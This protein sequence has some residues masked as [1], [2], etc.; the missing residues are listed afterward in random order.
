MSPYLYKKCSMRGCSHMVPMGTPFCPPCQSIAHG[1]E[2]KR[3]GNSTDR[4]YG[5]PWPA[6]RASY[7]RRHPLCEDCLEEGKTVPVYEVHHKIAI[8]DGGTHAFKNLRSLC[9]FHHTQREAQTRVK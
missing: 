8:R 1:Q 7:V 2:N 5:A 4:G 3:R 9:K 6:I